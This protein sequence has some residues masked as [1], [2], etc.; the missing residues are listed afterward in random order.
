MDYSVYE[1]TEEY[2]Q[3]KSLKRKIYLMIQVLLGLPKSIF[4][5]FYYFGLKGVKLPVLLSHK[6]KFHKLKGKVLI[7][8]KYKIGMIKLGFQAPEMY[9]NSKLSFIWINDGLVEFGNSASI[10]NGSVIRNY[11]HLILGEN[12]HVSAPSRIICYKH[13]QFGKDILIGWDCE[14]SDGDAHKIYNLIDKN[15][16]NRMNI[17]RPIIIGDKVW[18]SA[19][20]KVLKGVKLGNNMVIAEG[21]ILCKSFETSNIVVGGNPLRILKENIIWDV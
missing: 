20:T 12:F 10:R 9:D 15:K 8:S 1:K 21:T 6:V 5:N 4:F 7:N 11:G 3:K 14:F 13:I 17:N 18:F 19:H 16:E 2:W